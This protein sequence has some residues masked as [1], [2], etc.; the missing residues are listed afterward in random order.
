MING[1]ERFIRDIA[2]GD[3]SRLPASLMDYNDMIPAEDKRKKRQFKLYPPY[4]AIL[5]HWPTFGAAWWNLGYLVE[6]KTKDPKYVLT[7]EIREK[8]YEIYDTP[9]KSKKRP[10]G[11]LGP[12]EYAR[13]I[14]LPE[15]VVSKWAATLGL[16]RLKEPPWSDAELQLLDEKGYFSP[17]R[18]TLIFKQHGFNRTKIGILLM[19]RR[20]LAMKASPY[21]SANSLSKLLGIDAHGV[22]NWI[23]KGWLRC[24]MKGTLRTS[25]PNRHS[26]DTHL[27]H[28]DWLYEFICQHP[29]EIELKKVDQLWFLHIITRG[30]IKFALSDPSKISLRTECR[31]IDSSVEHRKSRRRKNENN[32]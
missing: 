5:R 4:A 1:L 23:K 3:E 25:T 19:R 27:I 2:E 10:K 28:Q 17:D 18:L 13:S 8:L 26:G 32:T 11:L 31:Q 29:T 30:E 21:Y 15:H 16:A 24:E 20:R 9:F 14:G 12:K 22:T 7:D 6:V